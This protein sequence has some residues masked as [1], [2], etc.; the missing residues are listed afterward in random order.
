MR[1]LVCGG[2]DYTDRA[3]LHAELDR[4]H[5]EYGFETIIAGAAGSVDTLAVEWAQ[6]HGIATQVFRAA[7]WGTLRRTAGQLRNARI[8]A[9]S[10]P[11]IVVA[12]PGGRRTANMVKQAKA[13]G[14]WVLTVE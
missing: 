2:L 6:A 14:V 11:D 3:E 7:A 12:F 8:L 1:V 13:A 9:E 10:R 5:A 4:L